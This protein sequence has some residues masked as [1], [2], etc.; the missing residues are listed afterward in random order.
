MLR[1]SLFVFC[2]L[3]T[4]ALA[5]QTRKGNFYVAGGTTASYQFTNK[6]STTGG[7]GLSLNR[8]DDLTGFQATS[9]RSGYFL[10]NRLLVG[11]RVDYLNAAADQGYLFPESNRLSLK[12]FARYYILERG[13]AERPLAVFGELGFGTFA[14]GR[15]DNYETDFHLGAGAELGLTAG[16]LGTANL[17]YN[18]NA[19]GLNY[20]NL[21]VGLNVLTGQL[22]APTATTRLRAGTITTNGQWLHLA[23]GRMERGEQQHTAL[24]LNLTPRLGYF[25]LDNLL[26]ESSLNLDYVDLQDR[27]GSDRIIPDGVGRGTDLRV[28][29]SARYYALQLGHLL[30]FVGA[31]IG[32]RNL[33]QE[34]VIVNG[35]IDRTLRSRHWRADVGASYMLSNALALDLSGSYLREHA[36]RADGGPG[37]FDLQD[38]ATWRTE[39]GLRFFLANR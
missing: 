29:L 35:F 30:P 25:V 18:A 33:D 7:D 36:G 27:I 38:R 12:P 16:V 2:L 23:Y 32:Y 34:D 28:D 10:T 3:L 1:T 11:T 6:P 4:F 39:V 22:S 15:G 20:T 9:F 14:V 8:P 24:H 17:N 19:Y 21:N 13:S 37:I 31:G 5:A 26:I